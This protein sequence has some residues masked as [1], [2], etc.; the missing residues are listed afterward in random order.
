M[1]CRY[2][3]RRILIVGLIG[4]V[5]SLGFAA[6]MVSGELV[7][8]DGSA[9]RFRVVGHEG[10]FTAPPGAALAEL[11]G[12]SVDVELA[13]GRVVQISERLVVVT[14]VTSTLEIVRGKLL[15]R[16]PIAGSFEFAGDSRVYMAPAGVAIAPYGGRWVEATLDVRGQVTGLDLVSEPAAAPVPVAPLPASAVSQRA[17][18]CMVD[19]ATTVASGSSVCRDGGALRCNDGVWIPLGT[20]CR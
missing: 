10:T 19:T 3:V 4:L 16:D 2:I 6:D 18:P 7:V 5:P 12:K 20:A 14:P 17:A 1:S 13:G 15:V 11:E 8:L 9:N